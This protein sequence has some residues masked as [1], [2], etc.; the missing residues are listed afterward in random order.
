[1]GMGARPLFEGAGVEWLLP[2]QHLVEHTT[3]GINI[4]T[5]IDIFA[6]RLFRGHIWSRAD[7][8]A[9]A[10]QAFRV[11]GGRRLLRLPWRAGH[12]PLSERTSPKSVILAIPS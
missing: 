3:D 4:G 5:Q 1:M 2:G 9:C 6:A 8:C 10:R 7:N 11:G 12:L